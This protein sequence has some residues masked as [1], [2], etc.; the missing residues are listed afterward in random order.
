MLSEDPE[1]V[2]VR[3][4]AL[5]ADLADRLPRSCAN[6]QVIPEISRAGGGSL[7]MCD[8]PTF[9]LEVEFLQGDA[10]SCDE[11]LVRR[12]ATPIVARV[13]QDRLLCDLRTVLGAEERATIAQG[14]L[15]YF[16]S[17]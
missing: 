15:D 8:I 14:I 11:Y 3:A 16:A 10:Q 17:L 13:K 9:A 5:R 2:R 6:L 7:P 12:C 1:A 4:E